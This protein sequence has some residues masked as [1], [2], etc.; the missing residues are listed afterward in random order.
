MV[1]TSARLLQLLS[2]L[3]TR[4][5]WSGSELAATLTIDVR[6]V[7]RDV[8]RLRAL[9][10]PVEAASGVGGGYQLS[11]GSHLP[12]V[13]LDDDEAVA[14]AVALRAA[15]ASIVGI[16]ETALRL[17][18]KL[19][20]LL[21]A[22]LRTRAGALNNLMLTLG[23]N[24]PQSGPHPRPRSDADVL[25]RTAAAARDQTVLQFRY[26]AY[27]GRDSLREVEP[28]RLANYGRRWYLIAWDRNRSDWRTFRVDRI[29]EPLSTGQR[30]TPREPPEKLTSQLLQ[31]INQVPY[32][33]TLRLRLKGDAQ[34]LAR[35]LPEWIGTI[36][37]L[38]ATHS[39]LT[40][41][42]ET[43]EQILSQ[44]AVLGMD[45]E[46]ESDAEVWREPLLAVVGRLQAALKIDE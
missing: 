33:H 1:P 20:A 14:I 6:T 44:L 19:E 35:Q 40:T 18:S 4:R 15:M 11:A 2:L 38:D 9:G 21:P 22:P 32:H 45:F 17:L 30:Y 26:R 43:P 46:L 27:D 24:N 31:T 28:A 39:R 41:G 5:Y 12:P 7:R 13:Q 25:L 8:D 16:E 34:T 37:P 3:Q 29:S 10:Y 36:E 23:T 42:G